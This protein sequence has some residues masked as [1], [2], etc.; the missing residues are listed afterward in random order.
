MAFGWA[1]DD[2]GLRRWSSATIQDRIDAIGL[3]TRYFNADIFT[4]AFA[5]PND[6]R[7]LMR[8]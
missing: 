8:A 7:D 4:A 3:T 5:L 2:A 6:I 1:T